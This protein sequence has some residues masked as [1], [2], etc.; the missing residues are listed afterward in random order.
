V[1]PVRRRFEP[2]GARPR[3]KLVLKRPSNILVLLLGVPGTTAPEIPKGYQR[4]RP[5][6]WFRAAPARRRG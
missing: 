6:R 4:V 5:I 1:M 3:S 2:M